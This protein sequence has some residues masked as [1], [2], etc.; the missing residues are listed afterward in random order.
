MHGMAT[1]FFLNRAG[2]F[3]QPSRNQRQINLFNG[4]FSKLCRQPPVRVVGFG[5]NQA[6]ARFFVESMDNS[7]SLFAADPREFGEMMEQCVHQCVL[8]LTSS[9]M[10]HESCRFVD[11]DQLFI[12][13][14][15][16]ERDRFRLIVDLFWRWLVNFNPVS[17]P[18]DIAGP[19]RQPI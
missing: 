2:G 16:I 6:T 17:G 4:A 7:G 12:L 15:N 11:H 9:G 1:D 5:N 3:A 10:N 19:G 14:K 8:P 13:I 18:D